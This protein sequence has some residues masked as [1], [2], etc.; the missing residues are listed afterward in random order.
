[1]TGGFES[2]TLFLPIKQAFAF[3]VSMAVPFITVTVSLLG[4][5][6]WDRS[7]ASEFVPEER[8]RHVETTLVTFAYNLYT[9]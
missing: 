3:Q 8:F 1:M 5:L 7:Q 6:N 9:F 4:Q 2:K